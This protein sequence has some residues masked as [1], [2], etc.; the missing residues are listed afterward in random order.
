MAQSGKVQRVVEM[1]NFSQ[2]TL[3][4][5][6]EIGLPEK[7]ANKNLQFSFLSKSFDDECVVEMMTRNGTL[8]ISRMSQI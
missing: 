2:H 4:C 3:L 5:C 6:S 8:P 7:Y 1:T